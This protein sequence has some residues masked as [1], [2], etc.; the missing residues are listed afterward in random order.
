[1]GYI[2]EPEDINFV[3]D[4]S[5]LTKADKKHI[6]AVIAQYKLTGKKPTSS[7][8]TTKNKIPKKKTSV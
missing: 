6:S 8:K 3:V 5:P 1:M 7:K 2:I 4:P